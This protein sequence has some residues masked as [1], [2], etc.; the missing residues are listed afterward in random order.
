MYTAKLLNESLGTLMHGAQLCTSRIDGLE[1]VIF[2]AKCPEVTKQE[3]YQE[4]ER[5]SV[6]A[7]VTG[8]GVS[9]VSH[10]SA[11]LAR[12]HLSEVRSQRRVSHA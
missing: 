12:N 1:R 5:K 6:Y 2:V 4:K 8:Y 11:M 7:M 10:A 3:T 9:N